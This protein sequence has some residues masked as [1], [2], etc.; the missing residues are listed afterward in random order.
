MIDTINSLSNTTHIISGLTFILVTSTIDFVTGAELSLSILYL[1]PIVWICWYVG[2]HVGLMFSFLSLVAWAYAH[3]HGSA[4][5]PSEPTLITLLVQ[6]GMLLAVV[7]LVSMLRIDYDRIV[8]KVLLHQK[9]QDVATAAQQFI[10]IVTQNISIYNSELWLWIV[11]Q[12]KSGK[13]IPSIVETT[14]RRI[15]ANT[16]VFTE[17]CFSHRSTDYQ[18]DWEHLVRDIQEKLSTQSSVRDQ[19]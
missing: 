18:L 15:G 13:H 12:K 17:T 14:C 10:M 3:Y 19:D 2:V 7:A 5:S 4:A 8:G 9:K 11:K 1:L 16:A 6:L